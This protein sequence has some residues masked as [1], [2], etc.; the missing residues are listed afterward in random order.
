MAVAKV[1]Q[2]ACPAVPVGLAVGGPLIDDIRALAAEYTA[3]PVACFGLEL[4]AA[5]R[6]A[7]GPSA[8]DA[9]YQRFALRPAS[10]PVLMS[11]RRRF[12]DWAITE[13]AVVNLACCLV[14][15]PVSIRTGDMRTS[16][17]RDGIMAV[18]PSVSEMEGWLQRLLSAPTLVKEPFALACLVYAQLILSHPL[19]D[20]N[21]RT[22]RA[23]FS[24]SLVRSIGLSAPCLPLGVASY[25]T[26]NEHRRQLLA[27]GAGGPWEPFI[28]SMASLVR[29]A[30]ELS[31]EDIRLRRAT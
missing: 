28:E 8:P 20:G 16:P 1:V 22:A 11:L 15:R 10:E 26:R 21:G 13:E 23:L 25:V 4:R 2:V 5:H 30:T 9:P 3:D 7:N 24:G 27:L 31:R 29:V 18:Y 12:E 17:G 6:V 19:S 14:G